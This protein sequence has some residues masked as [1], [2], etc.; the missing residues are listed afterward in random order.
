[1]LK[2]RVITALILIPIVIAALFL[3]PPAGFGL[4]IIAISGLAGWE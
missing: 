1:M 3:L 2:Y 4:V